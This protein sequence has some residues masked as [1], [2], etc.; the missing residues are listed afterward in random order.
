MQQHVLIDR[1]CLVFQTLVSCVL[2]NVVVTYYVEYTSYEL[3]YTSFFQ[4]NDFFIIF[5]VDSRPEVTS[6]DNDDPCSHEQ[7]VQILFKD[8]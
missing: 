1:K 5:L 3:L 8:L 6:T 2:E 4:K 7:L